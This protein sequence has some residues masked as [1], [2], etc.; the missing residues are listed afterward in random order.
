MRRSTTR[1]MIMMLSVA[2][3]ASCGWKPGAGV[4]GVEADVR[5]HEAKDTAIDAYIFG[6]PL[7]TMEMTR[8][9]MTN[10]PADEGTR[11][12]MGQFLRMQAYPTAAYRDVTAPNADTLY[13]TSW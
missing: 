4:K 9:V 10:V 1:L 8:R 5:E 6:Y 3:F 11:A 2:L 7:V 13:T 12:P